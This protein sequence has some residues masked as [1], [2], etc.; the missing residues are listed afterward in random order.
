MTDY[1]ILDSLPEKDYDDITQLAAEICQTQISLISLIDDSRQWF[2]SNRGLSIR[3]TPREY[4]FCTH[5]IQ[6]PSQVFV[7]P[8]SRKDERFAQNPL[9]TGDPNVIFY[10]GAPLIDSKGFGLG[11]LCV[12]DNTPRELNEKQITGLKIL[13][14]H[15]VNLIELRKAD[16]AMKALQKALEDNHNE[17]QKARHVL[18]AE[19]Y[20]RVCIAL[21]DLKAITAKSSYEKEESLQNLESTIGLLQDFQKIVEKM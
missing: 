5:A 10:A 19:F 17:A 2:K 8:D 13:A 21:E 20:P 16:R 18:K 15:V 4:A 1:N 11:S 6:N 7:V 12:I 3:E 14:K 9:V